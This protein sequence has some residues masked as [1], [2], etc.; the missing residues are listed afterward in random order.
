M[1][2][3]IDLLA[4]LQK[5]WGAL[6]LVAGL[7]ILIQAFGAL[8]LMLSGRP[9]APQTGL[10][11]GLTTALFFFFAVGA[12]VWGGV[13][14]YDGI[15]LRRR[16]PWARL[17]ALTLAVINLFFL[18]FGTALAGYAFWVLLTDETRRIFYPAAQ[19]P[20]PDRG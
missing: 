11:A 13:H 3:H 16:R 1:V 18:P 5:I 19:R 15:G 14:I 17:V 8:A 6:S 4:R 7:A 10:A 20:A 2:R 9:G 12:I